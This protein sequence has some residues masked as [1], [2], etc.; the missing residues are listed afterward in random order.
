MLTYTNILSETSETIKIF[1]SFGTARAKLA[2]L[3]KVSLLR[4]PTI[5]F[6]KS[7]G[8]VASIYQWHYGVI[9]R[10]P[11]SYSRRLGQ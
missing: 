4:D 5:V 10:D 2:F 1:K 9:R 3:A 6:C 11:R 8:V 7:Y